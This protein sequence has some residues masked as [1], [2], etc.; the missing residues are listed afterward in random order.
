MGS[1]LY[2][3]NEFRCSQCGS[4]GIPIVRRAGSCRE[5]GHLKKL[6]C[7]KCNK[8]TNHVECKLGTKYQLSDFQI[9][10]E[11]GN[12]DENGKRIL[13]YKELKGLIRDGKIEKKKTLVNCG[14]PWIGQEHLDSES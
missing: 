5:A 11:Y 14:D 1:H 4:K 6:W 12:F 9:E 10:F 2:E 13:S 8:E 7:L 3:F